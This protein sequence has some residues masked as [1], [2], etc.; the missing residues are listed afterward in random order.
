MGGCLYNCT[1]RFSLMGGFMDLCYVLYFQQGVLYKNREYQC[2]SM[3]QLKNSTKCTT[4]AGCAQQLPTI[5]LVRWVCRKQPLGGSIVTCLAVLI[6]TSNN[7]SDMLQIVH[8]ASL[9]A[10]A[11][12]RSLRNHCCHG[13]GHREAETSAAIKYILTCFPS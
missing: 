2:T 1:Y 9:S 10:A 11:S 5:S 12:G 3:S 6:L 4:F 8:G 7:H 13:F